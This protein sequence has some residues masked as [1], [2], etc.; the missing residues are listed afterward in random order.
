[1]KAL[2][3]LNPVVYR[4]GKIS[5][6]HLTKTIDRG[7]GPSP[8]IE[9]AP[10]SEPDGFERQNKEKSHSPAR[11]EKREK[12]IKDTGME[13]KETFIGPTKTPYSSGKSA[14]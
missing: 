6:I 11:G 14:H 13:L 8:D 7:R 2:S 1:M 4:T 12:R 5:L 3:C 10:I 9:I